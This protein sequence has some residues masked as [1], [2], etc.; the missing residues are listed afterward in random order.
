MANL[1]TIPPELLLCIIS[2]LPSSKSFL[3]ISQTSTYLRSFFIHHAPTI[4]NTHITTNHSRSSAILLSS[5]HHSSGW[6]VPQHSCV[7]TEERRI[8]RDKI[9]SS[10]C[11]CRS[12]RLFLLTSRRRSSAS[13]LTLSEMSIEAGSC[14]PCIPTLRPTPM[15]PALCRAEE[16]LKGTV[17]LTEPGPQYLVFLEKYGRDIEI[18]DDMVASWRKGQSVVSHVGAV[19]ITQEEKEKSRFNFTVG[20]YSVRRFLEDVESGMARRDVTPP[21][22]TAR[23][24]RPKQSWKDKLKSKTKVFR[25]HQKEQDVVVTTRQPLM[26]GEI[27]KIGAVSEPRRD[28]WLKGLIWYYHPQV[29]SLEPS[30]LSEALRPLW[31]ASYLVFDIKT[32]NVLTSL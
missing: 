26:F 22:S 17:K 16:A 20:N 32:N 4:C 15:E 12:C 5:H 25:K 3:A 8:Y 29:T 1:T 19:D 2:H 7:R 24:D 30:S 6:L 27:E 18:R 11:S 13:S 31:Q 28:E 23:D 14:F 10:N 21:N 9:L